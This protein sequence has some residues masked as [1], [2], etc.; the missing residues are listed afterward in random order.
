MVQ[1]PPPTMPLPT[2]FSIVRFLM[3]TG[4]GAI[5]IGEGLFPEVLAVN[6]GTVLTDEYITGTGIKI[7]GG[8]GVPPGAQTE[9][10]TACIGVDLGLNIGARRDVD[11][12]GR[13]GDLGRWA[14]FD[15]RPTAPA[16]IEA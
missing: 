11:S 1:P 16:P 10:G 4:L 12:S 14:G 13:A 6:D 3:V 7:P 8:R 9:H 5:A 2:K 15:V